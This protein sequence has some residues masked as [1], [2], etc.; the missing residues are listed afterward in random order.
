MQSSCNHN[1]ILPR[2]ASIRQ[3]LPI[4][5]HLVCPADQIQVVTFEECRHHICPAIPRMMWTMGLWIPSSVF[6]DV[7]WKIVLLSSFL[8]YFGVSSQQFEAKFDELSAMDYVSRSRIIWINVPLNCHQIGRQ[9]WHPRPSAFRSQKRRTRHGRSLP[10][11]RNPCSIPS[12]SE[13]ARPA[14]APTMKQAQSDTIHGT[15]HGA[16]PSIYLQLRICMFA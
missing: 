4:F 6:F 11:Q 3:G 13:W 16:M 15:T 2:P 8:Q 9:I 7:F 10:S 12:C 14:A 5:N 1:H